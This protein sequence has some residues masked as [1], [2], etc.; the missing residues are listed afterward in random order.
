MV[1]CDAQQRTALGGAGPRDCV[2]EVV[3]EVA[4]TGAVGRISRGEPAVGPG[5]KSLLSKVLPF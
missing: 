2:E 1:M 4:G 5:S 3:T